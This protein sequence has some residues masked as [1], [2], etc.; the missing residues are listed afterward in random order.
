MNERKRNYGEVQETIVG[1]KQYMDSG[2]KVESDE[3]EMKGGGEKH[4]QM[5]GGKIKQIGWQLKEG[6]CKVQIFRGREKSI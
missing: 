2:R 5:E 6:Q 1:W 4:V 3:E